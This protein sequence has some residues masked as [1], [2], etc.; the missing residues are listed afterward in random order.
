MT[1]VLYTLECSLTSFQ[2]FLWYH[3]NNV[4]SFIRHISYKI[5]AQS[6][7][8]IIVLLFFK[9]VLAF[10]DTVTGVVTLVSLASPQL[11]HVS[12]HSSSAQT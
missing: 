3:F 12:H 9:H 7:A 5:Y 2:Y 8:H 4:H 6:H 10:Q 1:L 11:I